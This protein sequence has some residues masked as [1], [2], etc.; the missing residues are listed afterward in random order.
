MNRI[1]IVNGEY[2]LTLENGEK[3]TCRRWL[4]K[5]NDKEMWHIVVPKEAREI[6]GRTYIRE[7]YFDDK[8]YYEFENKTEHRSGIGSGGWRTRLTKEELVKLEMVEKTIEDLKKIAMERTPVKI[9]MNSKE[10]I[11]LM[12]EK[13]QKKLAEM[14]SEKVEESEN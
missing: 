2:I 1:E 5:K 14:E 3:Y 10:G 8:D 7:S 9:D 13:L 11:L 4:E 12:M 6:C